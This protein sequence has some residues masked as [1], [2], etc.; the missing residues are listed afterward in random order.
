[1]K[2]EDLSV[3][4]I[5]LTLFLGA[6]EVPAQNVG[7]GF[8]DPNSKLAVNG[9]LAIG[10]DFN[11]AAPAN[12]AIIQGTVGIG[13]DS[14][15]QASLVIGAGISGTVSAGEFFNYSSGPELQGFGTATGIWSLYTVGGIASVGD[16]VTN[17]NIVSVTTFELSDA[18]LKNLI[19]LSD[20]GKD[21]QTLEKLDVVDYT[22]K[23]T[24]ITGSRVF[25]KLTAQQ[26]EG[27]YPEAVKKGSG[28]I[29]DIYS[30]G[31][32]TKKSGDFFTVTIE[33]ELN[34]KVG[35]RVEIYGPDGLPHSVTA[36]SVSGKSFS[37]R[38]QGITDGANVFVYGHEVNDLRA[39]DYDAISMLNV[40]ATQELA[41]R[42]AAQAERIA[43]LETQV[44]ELQGQSK[45]LTDLRTE[46]AKLKAE[47][48]E[49]ATRLEALEKTVVQ[50]QPQQAEIHSVALR[51]Q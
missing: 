46:N 48:S 37:G 51:Q 9:N 27:I 17:S 43:A 11:V 8:S 30:P 42:S 36:E 23:D 3:K 4:F 45:E 7:I 12:G 31:R 32:A 39:L 21:L 35:D 20:S 50:A 13:T 6:A 34:L 18:R 29:P 5:L 26:V 25:K 1:M 22:M 19:G 40:S 38:M 24:R 49:L 33:K 47:T 16:V 2:I 15:T 41:K 10:A 28:Q 44:R 14:P